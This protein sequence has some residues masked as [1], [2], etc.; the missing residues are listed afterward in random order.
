MLKKNIALFKYKNIIFILMIPCLVMFSACVSNTLPQTTH[1]GLVLVSDTKFGEVYKKPY[2]QL[3]E[4]KKFILAPCQVAFEKNWLGDQ[5]MNRNLSQRVSQK[6]VNRIKQALSTE[7]DKY[8]KQALLQEPAYPLTDITDK[9]QP[10]LI[11]RPSII[12]LEINAPDVRSPGRSRIFTTSAGE[13]TLFLELIDSISGEILARVVDK[14]QGLDSGRMQWTNSITNRVEAERIL[15]QWARLLRS[16]LD[17]A[18][19]Q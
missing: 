7:C 13:M 15:A 4:Y 10:V 3:I 11:L 8:F 18:Y 1:D 19:K 9:D 16:E 12:N 14:R 17:A 5:N 2:A 6:D